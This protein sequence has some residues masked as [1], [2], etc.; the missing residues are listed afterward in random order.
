VI[1]GLARVA[2]LICRYAFTEALYLQGTPKA[3][4]ELRRAVVKLY[5][6][7]LGYLSKARRYF[8]QG[9]TSQYALPS[10]QRQLLTFRSERMAKSIIVTGT[11][12]EQGIENMHTAESEISQW[13]ALVDRNG[14][15]YRQ[16][17]PS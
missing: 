5:T 3:V 11:E 14:V 13:M 15:S 9:T 4:E 1:E 16:C 2:E 8:E 12:L 6:I 17:F 10:S 7:V